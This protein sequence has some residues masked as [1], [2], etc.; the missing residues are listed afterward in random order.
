MKKEQQ[1][2]DVVLLLYFSS[3]VYYPRKN[4]LHNTFAVASLDYLWNKQFFF[5]NVV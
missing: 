5:K 4:D 2:E 1:I 3:S